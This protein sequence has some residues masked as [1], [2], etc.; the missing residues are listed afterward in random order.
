MIVV[1]IAIATIEIPVV[2][3]VDLLS[4]QLSDYDDDEN[5]DTTTNNNENRENLNL[6]IEQSKSD[7]RVAYSELQLCK[8]QIT[9]MQS[10][11]KRAMATLVHN[12]ETYQ[13]TGQLPA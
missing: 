6:I 1:A 3:V 7:Y 4:R 8:Q 11:K 13:E 5:D 9:E 2:V 10:L 12:F